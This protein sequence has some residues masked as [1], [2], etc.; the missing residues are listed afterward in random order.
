MYMS[1]MYVYTYTL[2]M[3]YASAAGPMCCVYLLLY[4]FVYVY[5]SSCVYTLYIL[6]ML[7]YVSS[8]YIVYMSVLYTRYPLE[9]ISCGQLMFVRI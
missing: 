3:M 6:Y 2:Y 9:L 1:N 4:M 5:S 7:L 8:K